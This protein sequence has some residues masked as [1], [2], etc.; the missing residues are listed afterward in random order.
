MRVAVAAGSPDEARRARGINAAFAHATGLGEELVVGKWV[1]EVSPEPS[2]GIVLA[3]YRAALAERRTVRWREMT[4][5]PTGTKVGEV[6]VTPI[7][8]GEGRCTALVGTV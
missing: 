7:I 2:L 3:R 8:D 6:S 4:T 1:D 5:Y